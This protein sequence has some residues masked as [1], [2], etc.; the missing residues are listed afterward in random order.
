MVTV[1]RRMGSV[2]EGGKGGGREMGGKGEEGEREAGQGWE[3][4]MAKTM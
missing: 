4:C 1:K 3:P 2:E